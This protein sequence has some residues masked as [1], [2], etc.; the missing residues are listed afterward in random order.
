MKIRRLLLTL[1]SLAVSSIAVAGQTGA[2]LPEEARKRLDYEVGDWRSKSEALDRNGQVTSTSYSRTQRRYVIPGR[3]L[4]ISGVIE[5]NSQTF[6]AWVYYSIQEKKYCLTSI[7]GNGS[8][9][10]F[11]GDLGQEF[12]WTSEPRKRPDGTTYQMRFTHYDFEENSFTAL[13]ERSFDGGK[14]WIAFSRQSLTRTGKGPD[15][16]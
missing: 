1:V 4:E 16:E 6:R 10:T 2:A 12:T 9:W 11:K 8:L 13:G 3:V 15:F 7:D 14:T 5:A